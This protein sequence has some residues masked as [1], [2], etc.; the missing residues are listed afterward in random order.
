M[1]TGSHFDSWR[2]I[3]RLHDRYLSLQITHPTQ[4][5]LG[6]PRGQRSLLLLAPDKWKCCEMG[7][8]GFR[9]Y[10]LEVSRKSNPLQMSLQRQHLLLSNLKSLSVFA[11]GIWTRDLSADQRSPGWANQTAE[12]NKNLAHCYLIMEILTYPVRVINKHFGQKSTA[13]FAICLLLL[14]MWFT[15]FR[16][17]N[18]K[19]TWHNS[20]D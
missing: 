13:N 10:I 5:R 17:A 2:R 12:V 6:T 3:I 15:L 20:M 19:A 7:P 1:S 9:P 16:K 4:E 18:Y 11:V 14:S 8:T